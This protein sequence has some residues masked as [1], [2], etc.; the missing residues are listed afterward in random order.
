ME[1]RPITA[2]SKHNYP[3]QPLWTRSTSSPSI[4]R[5]STLAHGNTDQAPSSQYLTTQVDWIPIFFPQ[6]SS[7]YQAQLLQYNKLIAPGRG[8]GL[9]TAPL[10]P[11]LSTHSVHVGPRSRSSSKVSNKDSRARQSSQNCHATRGN[12]GTSNKADRALI[13]GKDTPSKM[14][15]KKSDLSH[16]L[17]TRSKPS[18]SPSNLPP[19]S[20]SVPSTPQQH[21]RK[22]SFESRDHSPNANQ[23]H[24]PRSAYSE[25]NGALPSLRPLPPRQG[26]CKYESGLKY[27]RRRVPYNIGSETLQKVDLQTIKSKLS[28]DDERKL[29]TDMRELYDRLQPT[30][31]VEEKRVMLVQKLEKLM[32]NAWPGHDI[33]VHLFGSSGNL[34]CSDDSDV[35]ICIVTPWKELEGVCMLAD[36]LAKHGMQK[37]VCVSSAKVPIVKIW[38]PELEL[39]C[40]M[41]VNN[42]LALE[43]TR[44]IKTY[45]QID[46][47][48]RPLAMIIKYWTRQRIV[49]DAAFGG[50]LSSY[51]WI[52]MI[53]AF[54]QL[55]QPPVLPALHQRPHQKLL[56]KDGDI[57]AF[58]DD[59]DKLQGFGSKN[60]SSL[61]ELLFEFFRFYA[62]EFDYSTDV[63]S[64]RLGKVVSKTEKKWHL[65]LNNQLC[66]EEPF[67][68]GRNLGNTADDTA[69][70][71]LHLELRRAFGLI[72]EGK[73]DECCEQYVYPKEDEKIFQK[74][75][76]VSRPIILRSASQQ[77]SNRGNRGGGY[78]GNRQQGQH[79]NNGNNN[80]RRASSSVPY[81]TNG[82]PMFVPTGYPVAMTPQEAVMYMQPTSEL[83]AQTISALTLQ[84]NNL[85][86]LQ[87]AQSQA[88]NIQ[89]TQM[90]QGN[91]SQTQPSS[92]ERSRTNSFDTPPLSA[93]LRPEM[94][95]YPMQFPHAFY[96]QQTFPTYPSSPSTNHNAD[97][98][99]SSHRSTAA[100]EASHGVA[101]SAM[102]SQSQPASRT[103]IPTVQ[104]L[105]GAS[106]LSNLS[107]GV[108]NVPARHINGIPMP[109]FIPDEGQDNEHDG[110]V[111]ATPPEDERGQSYY[112]DPSSPPRRTSATTNSIPAFGDIGTQAPN[113][114]PNPNQG[115]GRLSSDQLPQSIL[116][117]IKQNSRSPSPLGHNRAYSVGRSS[118]PL[119][120][121]PFAAATGSQARDTTPLV[122]NGSMSKLSNGSSPRQPAQSEFTPA[123]Y[124]GYDNPLHINQRL[125][126]NNFAPETPYSYP[127]GPAAPRIGN[128]PTSD[129]PVV[130]NGS[131]NAGASIANHVPG[132]QLPHDMTMTGNHFHVMNMSPMPAGPD[133]TANGPNALQR[134]P[135][136]STPS[137]LIAQLDLATE[138][139]LQQSSDQSH[140]S[141]V[142]ETNSPSP[143][144]SRRLELP[145]DQAAA[146]PGTI[147]YSQP[148]FKPELTTGKQKSPIEP[149]SSRLEGA[150]LPNP[151]VNGLA[152]ENGHI[153]GAKS[154]SDNTGNGW[155][156]MTRG[157]KKGNDVKPRSEVYPQ[158]EQLP[159]N[160]SERKGG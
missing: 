30:K 149:S 136:R 57:V 75:Q 9:Q 73:L 63:L 135:I 47:R 160:D 148:D 61:G 114:N 119:A 82:S 39:A 2:D 18:V 152:R 147:A 23:S 3:S 49:N 32:N 100:S 88:F 4:P 74:P 145:V 1:G 131:S 44:M 153:R 51:T 101:G 8:G 7:L 94:Y 93:P 6:Q 107:N 95:Y 133:G 89:H 41:N 50:T 118:A 68:I 35:D 59:I 40:D 115:R 132:S 126:M 36:L 139:R 79:R 12:H 27:S 28:E 104:N 156:K 81:D 122:V 37:V 120:S 124:A 92:A 55:R 65:A 150:P 14:P 25:T 105:A 42:T 138:H 24:S 71:G 80:S 64:V 77:Q 19:H 15:P 11:L 146:L 21:A 116:D 22:F 98:R 102:R 70:R 31:K 109:S 157:R 34:L 29:T 52:C 123:Q 142:Y 159:K 111:A 125:E 103:G 117:R 86:F 33:R 128:S 97:F 5:L 158:S 20:N 85:R 121:V 129:R 46:D 53:I 127:P 141:P 76:S 10:P 151:R 96:A 155:Q 56:R 62:H 84:E 38:D 110:S 143:S 112:A 87:Y 137:P 106:Q 154:E 134:F 72:A 130:V 69:F 48:V 113:P 140:L 45:V 108:A 144:F 99:R 13:T 26:G 91:A 66:V 78:R 16:P 67:N 60:K 54:L 17:A 43:N 83:M 58:A 90:M